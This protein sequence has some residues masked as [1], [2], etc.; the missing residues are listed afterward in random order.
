MGDSRGQ[1]QYNRFSSG[2]GNFIENNL[3]F[4]MCRAFN[5]IELLV[6]LSIISLLISITVPALSL[7][8]V[9]GRQLY[10]RNNL[11][12][13]VLA[14]EGYAHENDGSYVPG[15][16]D[17]FT[18]NLHRW[19]GVRENISEAFDVRSGPLAEYINLSRVK[20]PTGA[21]YMEIDPMEP[22][23]EAGSGGYGYNLL[24][25]G[26]KI[27]LSGYEPISC[28]EAAKNVEVMHPDQTL[29]FADTAMSRTGRLVEY[30]FA[31]PRYFVT[32]GRITTT[33]DPEPSI[34]FRHAERANVAWAD[35][36]TS[37]ERM[38]GYDGVNDDGTR[39]SDIELG[40]FEPMDNSMFDLE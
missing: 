31:E 28:K 27:W 23:Y 13:L 10:C 3:Q 37:S 19:F 22:D 6:V 5:L 15:S 38:G 33:W 34:H 25:I 4:S 36:H 18:D 8:R 11:R 26:S 17:I 9:K 2:R 1:S 32:K 16:S 20:C 12:Q 7:L 29:M 35:A 39:P 14:N 40:W 24:Y 21:D 30:S